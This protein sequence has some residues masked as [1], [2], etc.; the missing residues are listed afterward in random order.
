MKLP[1][2]CAADGAAWEARLV[3]GLERGA[4]GVEIVRR[5]V[6]VVDLLAVAASGQGRAALV[7]GSL[8][9][10]DVDAVDRLR[11]AAVV[12]VGVVARGDTDAEERLRSI[13]ITVVLPDDADPTVAASVLTEAVRDGTAATGSATTSRSVRSFADPSTSMPIP[14]GEGPPVDGGS[15][16]RR[17][18]VIAVWGPTGAPGRTLVATSLADEVARLGAAALLVDADVYG[19]T[20]AAALGLLD[21]SPGVAAACRSASAQRMDAAALAT[22]CWQLGPQ[23]RVLTGVPLASRWPELRPPALGGVLAAARGLADFTVVDCGFCLETDEELSFDTLA[24]RRNGATLAVLD[25]AD[26]VVAVG[27]ADPIGMQRLVRSLGELRD[28]EIEAPVWVVLNRVRPG[29]VPGDVTAELRAALERFAG[30]TPAAMLPLDQKAVDAS[31]A[32]GQLLAE[33]SPS[34]PLRRAIVDLAAALAGVPA[35]AG[36][37]GRRRR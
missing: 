26:L 11:A 31:L 5:C 19:G 36:R 35:P 10:L 14:P 32:H 16:G 18:S 33:S 8:R 12:P 25:D 20:V 30:R 7:A 27:S 22:L 6:D 37:R 15:P 28:A 34:S 17:G 4:A 23:F 3:T 2:L 29:V 13:G 1:V 24:P 21:E 9:R